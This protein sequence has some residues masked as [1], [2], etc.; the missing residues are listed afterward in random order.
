MSTVPGYQ[1]PRGVLDPTDP[2]GVPI[3]TPTDHR[4]L[5]HIERSISAP[6]GSD[7]ELLC[8]EL[9]RYL[10]A[11]CQHHWRPYSGDD[12][13]PAHMQCLWCCDVEWL[14]EAQR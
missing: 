5:W 10:N 12:Q 9:R 6:M 4:L 7:L 11:T 1:F 13:I 3:A 14:G 2:D 8:K